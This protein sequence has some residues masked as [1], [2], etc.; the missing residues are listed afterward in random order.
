MCA[1]LV[2]IVG[3]LE[4]QLL[5]LPLL[6][7]RG[8]EARCVVALARRR[9]RRLLLAWQ[10]WQQR[11]ATRRHSLARATERRTLVVCGSLL[12]HW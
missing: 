5:N 3:S 10:E 11:Q 8:W 2:R 9:R 1:D 6:Q 12:H 7:I 4:S